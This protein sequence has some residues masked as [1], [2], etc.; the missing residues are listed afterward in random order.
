MAPAAAVEAEVQVTT[1]EEEEGEEEAAV[2]AA[3]AARWCE[4]T[5]ESERIRIGFGRS[6]WFPSVL[7]AWMTSQRAGPLGSRRSTF[8][9][10]SH[11]ISGSAPSPRTG[12]RPPVPSL[13]SLC[14]PPAS[15][16]LATAQPSAAARRPAP[17]RWHAPR[18]GRRTDLHAASRA[19][20]LLDSRECL[21]GLD[22]HG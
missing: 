3:A 22:P 21:R 11:S 13:S 10:R 19:A 6:E 17:R 7:L 2:V 16:A 4:R 18:W 9:V 15:S 8:T 5:D 20:Q 1:E 14:R 12:H